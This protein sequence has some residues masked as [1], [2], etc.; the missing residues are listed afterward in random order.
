MVQAWLLGT[1]SRVS[2]RLAVGSEEVRPPKLLSLREETPELALPD[3]VELLPSRMD[4]GL[5]GEAG[6]GCREDWGEGGGS[7]RGESRVR[8][9]ST[10]QQHFLSRVSH[11]VASD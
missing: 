11:F 2:V 8:T 5:V 3:K 9:V 7:Q 4:C 1:D 6:I 10:H